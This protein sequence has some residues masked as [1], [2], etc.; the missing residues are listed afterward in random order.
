MG[1]W[2]LLCLAGRPSAVIPWC[3]WGVADLPP[4][5]PAGTHICRCTSLLCK[6][7]YQ[8]IFKL[9][10]GDLEYL[11]QFTSYVILHC[12]GNSDKRKHLYVFSV[13]TFSH[14]FRTQ[15]VLSTDTEVKGPELRDTVS[16]PYCCAWTKL[17]W[18]LRVSLGRKSQG[19]SLPLLL[20]AC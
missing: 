19:R 11:I 9:S 7:G 13:D 6:M 12:S 1:H 2:V 4:D 14:F 18:G 3:P 17:V 5:L 20:N 16:L 10:L 8:Y 15:L